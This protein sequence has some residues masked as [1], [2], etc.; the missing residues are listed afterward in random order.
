MV[1]F[2]QDYKIAENKEN[3][4]R[5]AEKL[6][7]NGK[8]SDMCRRKQWLS[9]RESYVHVTVELLKGLK[10]ANSSRHDAAENS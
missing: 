7:L 1:V 2:I 10:A 3:A 6:V 8:I 5:N 9:F 4:E